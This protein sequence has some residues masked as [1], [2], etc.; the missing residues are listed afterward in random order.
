MRLAEHL[1]NLGIEAE[2]ISLGTETMTAKMAA[3]ALGV[4]IDVVIKTIL[5]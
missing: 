2:L 5:F 4:P 1:A 3:E